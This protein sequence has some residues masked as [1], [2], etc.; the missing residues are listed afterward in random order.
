MPAPVARRLAAPVVT[1]DP[2]TACVPDVQHT[3]LIHGT[4][5]IAAGDDKAP[6]IVHEISVHCKT[7]KAPV[8]CIGHKELGMWLDSRDD[9]A[10]IWTRNDGL[11]VMIVVMVLAIMIMI[12]LVPGMLVVVIMM[13]ISST[14]DQAEDRG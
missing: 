11:V 3:V 12:V 7:V 9:T 5:E 8:A 4:I 13:V 2:V 1:F 6:V 14:G 10:A